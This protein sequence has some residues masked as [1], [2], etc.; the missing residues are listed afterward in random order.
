MSTSNLLCLCAREIMECLH[1]T[2]HPSFACS[3]VFPRIHKIS[4]PKDPN[5]VPSLEICSQCEDE[6]GCLGRFALGRI[7]DVGG[8]KSLNLDRIRHGLLT[9]ASLLPVQSEHIIITAVCGSYNCKRF[10]K[11]KTWSSFRFIW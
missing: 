11:L 7:K 4:F 3:T 6:A 9:V 2:V 1:L 10:C 5:I 8:L